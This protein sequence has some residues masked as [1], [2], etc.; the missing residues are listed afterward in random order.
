MVQ[1]LPGTHSDFGLEPCV[2]IIAFALLPLLPVVVKSIH[3]TTGDSSSG[4]P[5]SKAPTFNCLLHCLHLW[6]CCDGL[7]SSPGTRPLYPSLGTVPPGVVGEEAM[8]AQAWLE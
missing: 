3:E 8:L 2:L 1:F 4:P 5:D 7:A 6:L